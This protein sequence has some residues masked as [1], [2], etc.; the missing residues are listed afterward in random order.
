M[1][2]ILSQSQ[3]TSPKGRAGHTFLA[4][5]DNAVLLGGYDDSGALDDI[6]IYETSRDT[7]VI[8]SYNRMNPHP[9]PRVDFDCCILGSKLYLFGG[10]QSDGEQVLIMND[11]WTLDL[12]SGVWTMIMEEC[13]L[14][15]RMGHVCV[16][17]GDG[18]MLV[19]GGECMGKCFD[20]IWIYNSNTNVWKAFPEANNNQS[21]PVGRCSHSA[22]YQPESQAFVI[23]GGYTVEDGAPVYLNDLWA[24]NVSMLVGGGDGGG[25]AWK[26]IQSS[27]PSSLT[28][29]PRD[30][31]A[32]VA[33][34]D[35]HLLIAGGYGLVEVDR[36][37]D[38]VMEDDDGEREAGV[39]LCY[40]ADFWTVEINFGTSAAQYTHLY[41]GDERENTLWANEDG[42][43]GCKVLA[44]PD[45]SLLSFGGFTGDGFSSVLEATTM[46]QLS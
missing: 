24:I 44:R 26:L 45:G 36:D 3:A 29:S 9:L 17:L 16:A 32:L 41:T 8:C 31:P 27:D 11:L 12:N 38:M 10:M 7:W 5:G 28:P 19:H 18:Y 13:P 20:D 14:S 25:S 22:C 33:L 35:S 15:E 2:A 1:A 6:W 4:Y 37:D 40:L 46:T 42:R 21:A 23:F 34:P 30:L 39:D 43:R